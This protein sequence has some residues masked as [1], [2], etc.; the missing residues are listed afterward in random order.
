MAD[1]Q[2]QF[3]Q[4]SG[5]WVLTPIAVTVMTQEPSQDVVLKVFKDDLEVPVRAISSKGKG[6]ARVMFRTQGDYTVQVS[7][8]SPTPYQ[9]LVWAGKDLKPDLP[10]AVKVDKAKA[11]SKRSK[12]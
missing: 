12:P 6:H 4:S 10:S 9:L 8:S 1:P 2:G 5:N 11:A 7:A 3:F